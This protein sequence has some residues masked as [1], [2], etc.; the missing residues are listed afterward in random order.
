MVH[1]MLALVAVA[2]IL[3]LAVGQPLLAAEETHEGKVVKVESG[4]LTMTDKS[5]NNQHTHMVAPDAKITCD[6]KECKLEDL[7]EG[8]TVKVTTKDDGKTVVRIDAT[9]PK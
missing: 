2:L 3:A 1:R 4:K 6:G 7:K 9:K 8:F 5:D